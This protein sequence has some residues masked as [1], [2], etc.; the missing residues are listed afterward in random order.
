MLSKK[1]I[2]NIIIEIAMYKL[3]KY[4]LN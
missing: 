1:I 2:V 4:L 3:R